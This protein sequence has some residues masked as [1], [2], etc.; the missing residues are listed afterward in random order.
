MFALVTTVVLLLKP[1]GSVSYVVMTAQFYSFD[2]LLSNFSFTST[3][4]TN[5]RSSLTHTYTSICTHVHYH[6]DT[7]SRTYHSQKCRSVSDVSQIAHRL[8][9]TVTENQ[10]NCINCHWR[11]YYRNQNYVFLSLS[12]PIR[13]LIL[14]A[15]STKWKICVWSSRRRG[16][17]QGLDTT[18]S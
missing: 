5:W 8:L 1:C 16:D 2:P 15:A 9:S 14:L 13:L 6:M 12:E 17:V 4:V 10:D 11:F 3:R 7:F 18:A